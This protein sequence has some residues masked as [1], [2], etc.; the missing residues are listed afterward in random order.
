MKPV[1]K[2]GAVLTGNVCLY[3]QVEVGG[4]CFFTDR[5]T[6]I[7]VGSL[8]VQRVSCMHACTCCKLAW[9]WC[10]VRHLIRKY[11]VFVCAREAHYRQARRP[12]AVWQGVHRCPRA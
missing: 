11:M 3:I 5:V 6:L 12:D 1:Y 7:I 9:Q 10:E 8:A 2:T 4:E